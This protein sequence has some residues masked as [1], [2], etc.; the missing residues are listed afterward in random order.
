MKTTLSSLAILPA[1][2]ILIVPAIALY[3]HRPPPGH[4]GGFG[5]PTCADCHFDNPVNADGGVLRIEGLPETYSPGER[6][7]LSITL[8]RPELR[9]AG[10]QMSA[11]FSE[12]GKGSAR[13]GEQAG[14][15]IAIDEAVEVVSFRGTRYAHHTRTGTRVPHSGSAKWL[16][17]WQAPLT[18]GVVSIDLATNAANGDGSAFGDFIYQTSLRISPAK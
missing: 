16:L 9:R 15:L 17:E 18:P 4:T 2:V 7:V 6:Y 12:D 3:E 11:R 1:A 8:Q 14:E 13:A 10:F 5:E